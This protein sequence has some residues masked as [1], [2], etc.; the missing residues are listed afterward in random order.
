[1]CWC[2]SLFILL[3]FLITSWRKG[4]SFAVIP[5]F[6]HLYLSPGNLWQRPPKRTVVPHCPCPEHLPRASNKFFDP[7]ED[8]VESLIFCLTPASLKSPS[9]KRL[10]IWW[11][12]MGQ[13]FCCDLPFAVFS[14]LPCGFWDKLSAEMTGAWS[15]EAFLFHRGLKRPQEQSPGSSGCFLMWSGVR[16]A[17]QL[18][19]LQRFWS[20][21]GHS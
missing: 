6:V 5:H 17:Q 19:L 16:I 15:A 10:P 12:S 3:S 11:K 21:H 1:M 18:F 2:E 13:T 14:F 4:L 20:V 7:M 8:R 9:P